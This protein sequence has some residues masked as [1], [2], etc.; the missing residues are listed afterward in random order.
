[1]GIFDWTILA[2]LLVFLVMG[3]RKGLVGML[4]NLAGFVLSFL[5]VSHYYPLVRQGLMIRLHVGSGFATFLSICLILLSITMIVKI[6]IYLLDKTISV[7]HLSFLNRSLGAIFG[8]VN[9]LL[10]VIIISLI[11]DYIPV[12]SKPLGDSEKHRV[13]AGVCVIKEDLVDKLKISHQKILKK[14]RKNNSEKKGEK[15]SKE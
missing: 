2:F 7:L 5:L 13:Y 10:C 6:V 8:L 15:T 3:Y 11:I 9:A 12:L 1:M 4:I 14:Y